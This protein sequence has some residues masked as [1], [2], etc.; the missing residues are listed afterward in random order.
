[1]WQISYPFANGASLGNYFCYHDLLLL[2]LLSIQIDK[3]K[4]TPKI[5]QHKLCC[6]NFVAQFLPKNLIR[7]FG[8]NYFAPNFYS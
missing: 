4:N 6:S 5:F 8:M 2:L 7:K 1:M 3:Y